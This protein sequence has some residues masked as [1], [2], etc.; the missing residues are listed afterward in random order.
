MMIAENIMKIPR[1]GVVDR[2]QAPDTDFTDVELSQE[3]EEGEEEL[4][5]RHRRY[6][7]HGSRWKTKTLT[8]RV[9]RLVIFKKNGIPRSIY[10]VWKCNT[11]IVQIQTTEFIE[12]V[13]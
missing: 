3:K 13:K 8:Y 9:S 10:E 12:E 2:R 4:L 6:A 11:S 5:R 7:L 1:C